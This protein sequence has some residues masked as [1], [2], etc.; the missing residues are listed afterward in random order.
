MHTVV[1]TRLADRTTYRGRRTG[2][3][4]DWVPGRYEDQRARASCRLPLADQEQFRN[5]QERT[6]PRLQRNSVLSWTASPRFAGHARARHD[7]SDPPPR[8]QGNALKRMRTTPGTDPL[9]YTRSW[10]HRR[11]ARSAPYHAHPHHRTV[12]MTTSA[13]SGG[14]QRT[15]QIKNAT[16]ALDLEPSWQG[17]PAG[18]HEPLEPACA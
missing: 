4:H 17:A 13:S 10:K 5:Y 7:G 6:R 15:P 3:L 18:H 9:V 2:V 12:V 8:K 1:H 11:P 14:P 16:V